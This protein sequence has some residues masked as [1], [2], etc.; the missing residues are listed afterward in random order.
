MDCRRTRPP[1]PPLPTRKNT[2]AGAADRGAG[3]CRSMTALVETG[4]AKVNLTLR[5][6][7]RRMDGYHDL[8]SL[9]AFADCADRLTLTP[10]LELKLRTVGPRA[11]DCGDTA[12]N[13][14]LKAARL[15]AQAV[16]G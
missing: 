5:V 13:L 9:V 10:G 12:D 1:L 15:L 2:T 16:P 7:G 4:R 14:V 11:R 3:G 8:E 6:V